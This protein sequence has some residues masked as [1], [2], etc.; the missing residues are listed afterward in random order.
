MFSPLATVHT[1]FFC[2]FLTCEIV[3]HWNCLHR[4][5][6]IFDADNW[7]TIMHPYQLDTRED[8]V[9]SLLDSPLPKDWNEVIKNDETGQFLLPFG[10]RESWA[11]PAEMAFR[12]GSLIQTLPPTFRVWNLFRHLRRGIK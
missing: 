11:W 2:A 8:W 1:T 3:N 9:R 4:R 10:D 6:E 7:T 12:F 5:L